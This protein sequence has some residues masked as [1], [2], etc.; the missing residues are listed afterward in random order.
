VAGRG[1]LLARERRNELLAGSGG[2][3]TLSRSRVE[4][5]GG[6]LVVSLVALAGL[7]IVLWYD[8]VEQLLEQ[9]SRESEEGGSS[10]AHSLPLMTSRLVMV[11]SSATRA[12]AEEEL[13]LAV[14]KE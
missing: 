13:L 4:D 1:L 9:H 3:P 5:G 14:R 11:I 7:V 8:N 2:V 10:S 6:T 12:V